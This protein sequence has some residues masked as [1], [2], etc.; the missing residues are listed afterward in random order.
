MV[1]GGDEMEL[2]DIAWALEGQAIDLIVV[3]HLADVSGSRMKMRPVGGL[4]L[5]HVEEPQAIRAGE[6]P[7]RVFDVV[8]ALVALV[9]LGPLMV[10]VAL[11]IKLADGGPVFYRQPRVGLHGQLFQVWKFRSMTVDAERV[12]AQLRSQHGYTEGL[13]KLESDPRVTRI[14]RF[15]R[16]CSID[17]LPQL[18]NV[19]GGTMSLVGPRPHMLIEVETYT[20]V[21]RRRLAVRPGMTGLWQVSGRSNLSWSDAVRLDLYYR[22]NWSLVWDIGII[23]KT[24]KA[25]LSRDGA[26]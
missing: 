2:R 12:D 20:D 22:D 26:Y 19:I 18:F 14:G 9:F 4:P 1:A 7:K 13:F 23:L 16:R 11:L 15:I 5:L 3:P 17:E 24:V 21:A 6:W 10:L 8:G 25:V